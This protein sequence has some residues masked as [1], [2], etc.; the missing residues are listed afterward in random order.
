MSFLS[1]ED[2]FGVRV[3]PLEEPQAQ[4]EGTTP[5]R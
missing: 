5:P 2:D 3:Q 1:L 4:Q